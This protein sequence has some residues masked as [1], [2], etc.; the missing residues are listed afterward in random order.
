[1]P[2]YFLPS[3][4]I[5]IAIAALTG[6]SRLLLSAGQGLSFA[7][8]SPDSLIFRVPAKEKVIALSF[9]DGPDPQYTV[10]ILKTLSEKDARATFFVVGD[11]ASRYPDIIH[12]MVRQGN[13]VAN[14][15]WSHPEMDTVPPT[16][17]ISQVDTTSRLI[18][19]LTGKDNHF[20]RPPKG[21][22][23]DDS[24][25]L[26]AKAGYTTIMWSICIENKKAETPEKMA[27]RV[28][29]QIKPG[30]IILLHDGRLDRTKTV[31]A[32]PLLLNGLK[33]KG[34][35]AVTVG[36]LMGR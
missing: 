28:L 33:Q 25:E 2:K 12:Q 14:H 18:N 7:G 21:V 11:N 20:F 6:H 32:L 22:L 4:L 16:E 24:K 1:M 31:K 36:E 34:Y 10:P 5:I 9:D 35:K 17:L 27:Q 23:N 8:N 19:E 15:T 30:Q 13:E 29:D 3:M 26:L